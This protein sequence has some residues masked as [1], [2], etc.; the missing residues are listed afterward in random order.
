M[1]RVV[2][3]SNVPRIEETLDLL[4]K[5]VVVELPDP[6]LRRRLGHYAEPLRRAKVLGIYWDDS[7]HETVGVLKVKNVKKRNAKGKGIEYLFDD[8]VVKLPK[9]KIP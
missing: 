2:I 9:I 5:N 4:I 3:P 8:F 6:I 7:L 1:V